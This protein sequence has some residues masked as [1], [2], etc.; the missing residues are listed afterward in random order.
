MRWFSLVEAGKAATTTQKPPLSCSLQQQQRSPRQSRQQHRQGWGHPSQTPT[1]H[2]HG[3]GE[4]LK[5]GVNAASIHQGL[6]AASLTPRGYSQKRYCFMARIRRQPPVSLPLQIPTPA[7]IPP[8]GVTLQATALPR[9]ICPGQVSNV[10]WASHAA[11]P[12]LRCHGVPAACT[13]NAWLPG[14][15]TLPCIWIIFKGYLALDWNSH[16]PTH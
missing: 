7:R 11:C 2:S 12:A 16:R 13:G 10:P 3:H 1:P 5:V 14:Q 15:L 6:P 4:S 9:G 8:V